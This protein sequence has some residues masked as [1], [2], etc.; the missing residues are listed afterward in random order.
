MNPETEKTAEPSS[1]KCISFISKPSS[2][3]PL[4]PTTNQ[5]EAFFFPKKFESNTNPQTALYRDIT[6]QLSQP[7]Q[8]AHPSPYQ[9]STTSPWS[10]S[11]NPS[12]VRYYACE[13]ARD[14]KIG[15][16]YTNRRDSEGSIIPESFAWLSFMVN[17]LY[18][19]EGVKN[20]R[21]YSCR[22]MPLEY[23]HEMVRNSFKW[24]DEK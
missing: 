9:P 14:G 22:V 10:T 15:Q 6:F 17:D 3:H 12:G 18:L 7:Q 4:I 19:R 24:H 2:G 8:D 23:G 5:V 20:G 16:I 13:H 1:S 11:R 21:A